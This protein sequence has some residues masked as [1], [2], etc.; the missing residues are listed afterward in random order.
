[1]QRDYQT[2]KTEIV[3][4]FHGYHVFYEPG[5]FER[6]NRSVRQTLEAWTDAIAQDTL[7]QSRFRTLQRQ[8]LE[9]IAATEIQQLEKEVADFRHEEHTEELSGSWSSDANDS[10]SATSKEKQRSRLAGRIEKME[11]T[12]QVAKDLWEKPCRENSARKQFAS[13]LVVAIQSRIRY[14]NACVCELCVLFG[15]GDAHYAQLYLTGA[16]SSAKTP[17]SRNKPHGDSDAEHVRAKRLWQQWLPP[18]LDLCELTGDIA[19]DCRFFRTTTFHI[20]NLLRMTKQSLSPPLAELSTEA[21]SLAVDRLASDAAEL[22]VSDE[23]EEGGSDISA[24]ADVAQLGTTPG[25]REDETFRD[26]VD[27]LRTMLADAKAD[28]GARAR[29]STRNAEFV[30]G[31]FNP[32]DIFRRVEM[33]ITELEESLEKLWGEVGPSEDH[34]PTVSTEGGGPR[35]AA[36]SVPRH[37]VE[38]HD[39]AMKERR[40]R[41]RRRQRDVGTWLQKYDTLVV[42]E[43]ANALNKQ[44]VRDSHA[45]VVRSL[46]NF[47]RAFQTGVSQSPLQDG[48][49]EDAGEEP[50]REGEGETKKKKKKKS[51][52]NA[53]RRR[54]LGIFRFSGKAALESVTEALEEAV[55]GK[56]S[57]GGRGPSSSQVLEL[58]F[59]VFVLRLDP[60]NDPSRVW[61]GMTRLLPDPTGSEGVFLE[62]LSEKP[63]LLQVDGHA[64][65]E[66]VHNDHNDVARDQE[67]LPIAAIEAL[68]RDENFRRFSKAACDEF[69]KELGNSAGA[70]GVATLG[71]FRRAFAKAMFDDAALAEE[72]AR[73]S[74]PV[75]ASEVRG[76]VE[77]L[78]G[79]ASTRRASYGLKIGTDE[80][81]IALPTLDGPEGFSGDK[82]DAFAAY[83][84]LKRLTEEQLVGADREYQ[85]W[86]DLS[87]V[88]LS[89]ETKGGWLFAEEFGTVGLRDWTADQ[90]VSMGEPDA[91]VSSDGHDVTFLFQQK[92]W[93]SA[94]AAADDVESDDLQQEEAWISEEAQAIR[95]WEEET[96]YMPIFHPP[97]ADTRRPPLLLP[98][99]RDVTHDP[100]FS[101]LS[102]HYGPQK[103]LLISSAQ[104]WQRWMRPGKDGRCLFSL[105]NEAVRRRQRALE[106]DHSDKE[107]MT[108]WSL[109]EQEKQSGSAVRARG[110]AR[111]P[112]YRATV[113]AIGANARYRWLPADRGS[114]SEP[115]PP[116]VNAS[117]GASR[118]YLM[119]EG[120]RSLANMG[121]NENSVG[122]W[123]VKMCA[124]TRKQLRGRQQDMRRGGKVMRGVDQGK[125]SMR[126]LQA[127]ADVHELYGNAVVLNGYAEGGFGIVAKDMWWE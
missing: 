121:T 18:T 118:A 47:L 122:K 59:A 93:A 101:A 2:A 96:P 97:A 9:T 53:T 21:V 25:Q 102:W 64:V 86:P 103:L 82:F 62:K 89:L 81:G 127:H 6:T 79:A 14:Q 99:G 109:L 117:R 30:G 54:N 113:V 72:S 68:M 105:W 108:R 83:C 37:E 60:V 73:L 33:G 38:D 84:W 27:Q 91:A 65:V 7:L 87:N 78:W 13:K 58:R 110:E 111:K 120:S 1:M 34:P 116:G 29:L 88:R 76:L 125:N 80:I 15:G 41:Q 8:R 49:V 57:A 19:E 75:R 77:F 114:G 106:V 40:E 48:L 71:A 67:T 100:A 23:D 31:V 115:I 74:H 94:P 10:T 24:D 70:A 17:A 20:Q 90:M 35:G 61:F 63:L 56:W 26:E 12:L 112:E 51:K 124:E 107:F 50:E 43:M 32:P 28:F 52:K 4:L 95:P 66:D 39:T 16:S 3:K 22:R 126:M 104:A 92:A 45:D 55:Q 44:A 5:A 69:L 46:A 36:N 123:F 85:E 42:E 119:R 11:R 98:N